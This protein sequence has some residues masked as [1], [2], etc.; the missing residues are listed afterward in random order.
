MLS[1]S[2]I[3]FAVTHA[4]ESHGGSGLDPWRPRRLP[5]ARHRLDVAARRAP[6]LADPERP[7]RSDP[8]YLDPVVER[9]CRAVHRPVVER[10]DLRADEGRAGAVGAPGRT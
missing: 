8:Q 1:R 9:A 7:R 5:G 3:G 6:G 4:H 10:P 2:T